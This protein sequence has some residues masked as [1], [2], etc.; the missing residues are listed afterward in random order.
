MNRIIVFSLI[1]FTLFLVPVVAFAED[2]KTVGHIDYFS[3]DVELKGV[4]ITDNFTTV[5]ETWVNKNIHV[6]EVI[7]TWKL[8]YVELNI[9]GNIVSLEGQSSATFSKNDKD[10]IIVTL[11][12]GKAKAKFVSDLMKLK[13]KDYAVYGIDGTCIIEITETEDIVFSSYEGTPYIEDNYG[14]IVKIPDLQSVVAAFDQ[15]QK[16]YIFSAGIKNDMAFSV[17]V[18]GQ[19]VFEIVPDERVTVF[20]NGT[21]QKEMIERKLPEKEKIAQEKQRWEWK[22]RGT[23]V[24]YSDNY[25]YE[26]TAAYYTGKRDDFRIARAAIF[27]E[28]KY[29]L[30]SLTLS[31]DARKDIPLDD[32]YLN[33]SYPQ[34]ENMLNFKIGQQMLPF[35]LQTQT[36]LE[37]VLTLDYAQIVKYGFCATNGDPTT[38]D[39]DYLWDTGATIHGKTE[40][41]TDVFFM[42]AL[43]VFNGEKRN[44]SDTNDSK[45]PAGRVGFKIYNF[46][47]GAS[48]YTAKINSGVA[49]STRKRQGVDISL[50]LSAV[51]P[52]IIKGELITCDDTPNVGS[53]QQTTGWYTEIGLCLGGL[54]NFFKGTQILIRMDVLTPPIAAP[55]TEKR[56]ST[57]YVAGFSHKI[58]ENVIFAIAYE[59][60][61]QGEER[62]PVTV[63]DVGK[64]DEA[65]IGQII[66]K[67]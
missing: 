56:N 7:R 52:I 64:A 26:Q 16:T 60:I 2:T 21:Y 36:H 45:A 15:S 29:E 54:G 8:G 65:V 1:A 9:S 6:G 62:Y 19:D 28:T 57:K 59:K 20:N 53:N 24:I 12:Y 41:T 11:L 39:L 48:Y 30:A 10:V 22:I 38:S 40:L 67:F 34:A 14:T 51:A 17:A 37:D 47:L 44:T 46:S 35:G 55:A 66:I 49:E 50:D 27:F 33:L 63:T 3:G 4:S 18:K 13:V 32:M 42:Y 31:A 58:G 43:G 25:E 5:H 23:A 61:D